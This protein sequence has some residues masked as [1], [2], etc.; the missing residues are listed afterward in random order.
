[1]NKY[2][3]EY[4]FHSPSI[5]DEEDTKAGMRKK[6][7]KRGAAQKPI[8]DLCRRLHECGR[9]EMGEKGKSFATTLLLVHPAQAPPRPLRGRPYIVQNAL[10]NTASTL[11]N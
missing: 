6:Q 10:S 3:E 1:M 8:F 9:D 4:T 2:T 5:T 11:N 7:Q